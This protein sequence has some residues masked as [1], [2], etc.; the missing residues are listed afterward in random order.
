MKKTFALC[1]IFLSLFVTAN[2]SA[3]D[4]LVPSVSYDET[5]FLTGSASL[6]ALVDAIINGSEAD[7]GG[8]MGRVLAYFLKE[9]KTAAAYTGA[10]VGFA[11]L[12]AC[13][14]GSE[15]SFVKSSAEML[16]L[17]CYSVIAA[18]LLGIL[19][20]AAE[21]AF[22]AAG[23]IT[24]FVKMSVP[25]YIGIV[26]AAAPSF[27]GA[28]TGGIFL[29]TVNVMSSFAG[30]FM[31]NIFFCTGV[32]YI[33]N[34]MSSEI[35]VLRLIELVRQ[36]VFWILGFLLTVFAGMT[37]LSGISASVGAK[38]G[39]KAVKYTVGHAVP[40]VGGFLADS[41][42]LIFSS[43]KIFKNAFGTAGII[44]IFSLCLVPV[45]KLFCAGIMLKAASG[46]CEPFCDKRISDCTAD[47]GQTII[48]I[49][50]CVILLAVMFIFSL[51]VILLAVTGG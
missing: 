3:F 2:A 35:H 49:M 43:F 31:L 19:K 40:V 29:I 41:S 13:V 48:N 6:S 26:S 8:I 24:D 34:H 44:V 32:L 12:S 30:D 1:L 4:D 21:A 45:I 9:I 39:M 10:I 18:F 36:T 5:E 28:N 11:M 27:A 33:A 50:I 7:F 14:K 25:A 42:E 15:L 17:V 22:D 20:S 23:K 51:T 37:G 38:S 16:F 47:V 46:I